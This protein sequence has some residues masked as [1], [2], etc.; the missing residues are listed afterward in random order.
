MKKILFAVL[1]LTATGTYAQRFQIGIK[2]GV[3]FSNFTG[4]DIDTKAL[5]GFHAGGT[6]HFWLGDNFAILPEVLFSSQGA[7]YEDA[8]NETNLKVS[9]VQIPLF[10]KY[11]FNGG[12]YLEAGPQFGFK[13]G[14]DGEIPNV[15]IDEFANSSDIS[16][17]AG[18]GFHSQGGLGIGARY[19]AGVSK[20]GN[21]DASSVNPDFKNSVIQISLFYTLFNKKDNK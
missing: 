18:L 14:E 8:G 2:G 12:F 5:V 9:Y 13:V 21:F 19:L 20:V 1:L 11:R 15:P 4:G 7:K 6:L 3:N 17:G 16:I 10:A